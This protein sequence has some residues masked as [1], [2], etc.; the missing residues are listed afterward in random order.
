MAVETVV[1]DNR[2][3]IAVELNLIG[4]REGG[5]YEE[6]QERQEGLSHGE[7]VS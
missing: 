2:A 7:G 1:G 5:G 6:G 4:C 3:D